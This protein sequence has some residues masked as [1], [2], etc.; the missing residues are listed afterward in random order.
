[1]H[2]SFGT[3]DFA[4]RRASWLVPVLGMSL[5]A[6]SVA[7]VAGI[8]AARRLGAKL[9][10]FVGLTEVLFGVLFAWLILGELPTGMQL[11]GGVLI[12]GGVTLVRADEMGGSRGLVR[13]HRRPAASPSAAPLP[14]GP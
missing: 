9:A 1:M 7:Y 2:A 8:A 5:V 6:T 3:V 10:T 13:P 12:L 14:P 4:G 11:A